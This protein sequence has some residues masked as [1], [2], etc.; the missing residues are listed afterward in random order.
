MG[1][2]KWEGVVLWISECYGLLVENVVGD[3]EDN[4]LCVVVEME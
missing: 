2:D 3:G 4:I 1:F